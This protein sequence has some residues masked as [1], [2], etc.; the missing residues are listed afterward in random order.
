[1]SAVNTAPS[2]VGPLVKAKQLRL[3]D[4]LHQQ[5]PRTNRKRV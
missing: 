2:F 1:M 4:V 5:I 3:F